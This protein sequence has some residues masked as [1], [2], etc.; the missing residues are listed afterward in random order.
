VH[1]W[2]SLHARDYAPTVF[3]G[4][5]ENVQNSGSQAVAACCRFCWKHSRQK[6]GLPCVGLKGTVVSLPHCEQVVRVSVLLG[7]CPGVGAPSTETRFALHTLQRFGSFLNCL[8]WKNNCSPAV[9]IKSDPQSI[10]FST[11]SWNSIPHPIP[12]SPPVRLRKPEAF[13][14][15]ECAQSRYAPPLKH[16]P[17]FGPPADHASFTAST[18]NAGHGPWRNSSISECETRGKGMGRHPHGSDPSVVS[19]APYELSCGYVSAPRL[20]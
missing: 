2:K 7:T 12:R 15:R 5:S 8:S 4:T 19:L 13:R 14:T 18:G 17:G 10:H 1:A 20:P 11:L 6:T 9:K 3:A 16:F